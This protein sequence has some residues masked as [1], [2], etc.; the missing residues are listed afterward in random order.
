VFQDFNLKI[1]LVSQRRLANRK[2][3]IVPIEPL[4]LLKKLRTRPV[5]DIIVMDV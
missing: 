4:E 2:H 5:N 3:A 1:A